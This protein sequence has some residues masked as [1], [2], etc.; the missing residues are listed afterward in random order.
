MFHKFRYMPNIYFYPF[1][2]N[3]KKFNIKIAIVWLYQSER[4]PIIMGKLL[5]VN[6]M[7]VWPT[8]EQFK[9]T[10]KAANKSGQSCLEPLISAFGPYGKARFQLLIT[11]MWR[12]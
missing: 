3:G 11:K 6:R 5:T 4:R 7:L 2:D 8:L 10:K 1:P 9:E 12:L